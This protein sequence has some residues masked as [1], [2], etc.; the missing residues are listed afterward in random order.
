MRLLGVKKQ[1]GDPIPK[2]SRGL[3]GSVVDCSL[4]LS[5]SLP[6]IPFLL[7]TAETTQKLLISFLQRTKM[8]R[9]LRSGLVISQ[10]KH[11]L[12]EYS[13]LPRMGDL[14]LV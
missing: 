1:V 12:L 11:P 4:P 13:S 14:A 10:R 5:L 9:E 2:R 7:V 3:E 8:F 6:S